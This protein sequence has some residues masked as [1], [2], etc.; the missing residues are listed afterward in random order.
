MARRSKIWNME[1]MREDTQD[2]FIYR[3]PPPPS[4]PIHEVE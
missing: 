3:A 4:T 2:S 1:L